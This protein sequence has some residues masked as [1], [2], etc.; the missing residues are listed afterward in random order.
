MT[1][2]KEDEPI[3]LE[4]MP[5]II[6]LDPRAIEDLPASNRE[7]W[8]VETK[9]DGD[10][11]IL[12]IPIG[13]PVRMMTRGGSNVAS[14]FPEFA[15]GFAQIAQNHSVILDAELI[16]GQGKKGTG[17]AATAR[18]F[19]RPRPV[20]DPRAQSAMLMV[21]DTMYKDGNSLL[22]TPL[23]TRKKHLHEIITPEIAAFY[24]IF[25][26][27]Y[28]D[29]IA[30]ETVSDVAKENGF[31]G[32]VLKRKRSIYSQRGGKSPHWL[33]YKF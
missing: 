3:E 13:G 10:R 28:F 31:E 25:E 33:K 1:K 18:L 21:F 11:I 5:H 26:V 16:V 8:I 4:V 27:S 2:H 19:A 22:L 17:P 6:P 15:P 32:I 23:A 14:N 29:G 7:T 20:T 9:Y 24:G 12:Y 30:M